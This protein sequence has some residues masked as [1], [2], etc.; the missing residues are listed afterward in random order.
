[1][2]V[3]CKAATSDW[4]RKKTDTSELDQPLEVTFNTELLWKTCV[5]DLLGSAY[6]GTKHPQPNFTDCLRRQSRFKCKPNKIH[7]WMKKY[8]WDSAVLIN[9]SLQRWSSVSSSCRLP[10]EVVGSP[11]LEI[12]KTCLSTSWTTCFEQQL[13]LETSRGPFPSTSTCDS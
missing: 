9:A 7:Y 1:M 2:L 6:R 5:C 3:I 4:K 13:E 12:F 11:L 10:W 8:W